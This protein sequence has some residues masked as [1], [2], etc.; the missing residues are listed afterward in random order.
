M[1]IIK[2]YI[3]KLLI[4]EDVFMQIGKMQLTYKDL[5]YVKSKGYSIDRIKYTLNAIKQYKKN[6][7]YS[8]LKLTLLTPELVVYSFPILLPSK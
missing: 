3:E 7:K 6:Y 4:N 2:P 8:Y 1:E 5:E